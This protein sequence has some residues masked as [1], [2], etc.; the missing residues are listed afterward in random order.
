[1]EIV[2]AADIF[3]ET[4]HLQQ[5]SR[6]LAD[7]ETKVTIVSLDGEINNDCIDESALYSKFVELGGVEA[8]S[9]KIVELLGSIDKDVFII[10]FSAGAAACWRALAEETNSN[11]Q[12]FVG[13]YPGQIRHYLDLKATIDT[14]L[15]FPKQE[16]HFD[17]APVVKSLKSDPLCRCYES[18]YNHGFMNPM[19]DGFDEIGHQGYTQLVLDLMLGSEPN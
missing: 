14:H 9:L 10:G 19:S 12:S 4:R 17:L 11:L 13:F 2:I 15:I 8:Y 16:K 3:G 18:P 6:T 1:M 7:D 5:W